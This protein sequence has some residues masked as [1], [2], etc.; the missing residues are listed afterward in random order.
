VAKELKGPITR[1]D[2]EWIRRVWSTNVVTAGARLMSTNFTEA[3]MVAKQ[4]KI[5]NRERQLEI[6]QAALNAA[7]EE[8]GYDGANLMY[9]AYY[10][11]PKA[12]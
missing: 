1:L 5:F 3:E 10:E 8:R 6:E 2:R 9:R 7:I 4:R 12:T 11:T